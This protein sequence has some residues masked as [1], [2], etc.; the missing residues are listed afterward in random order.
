[1]LS[2]LENLIW[3]MMSVSTQSFRISVKNSYM[4]FWGVIRVN[5][6]DDM[7]YI[8][9][10]AI[11]AVIIFSAV[12]GHRRGL[13][14]TVFKCLSLAAAIILAYFFGH[15]VG[16]YIKTTPVYETVSVSVSDAVS[17]HF[18]KTALEGLDSAKKAQQDFEK[19][20]VGKTLSR[21]GFDSNDLYEKYETEILDG[22]N[23]LKENYAKKL[24]DWIISCL[25]SALGTLIVFIASLL[26]L[27]ILAKVFEAVF[28]LP[29]LKTVNKFG[30]G[31]LGL[32]LGFVYAFVACAVIEMLLPYIPEN[33]VLYMGMEEN[34]V[35]Y[36][37]FLNVN[38]LLL[39]FFG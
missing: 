6:G 10:L 15:A 24:A 16:D 3:G 34:T 23:S 28:K 12:M 18:D 29:L 35:L 38:P 4:L 11:V 30:G 13:V 21:L 36:K 20:D 32:I 14:K 33:P 9:D 2:Y 8:A 26:L 25:A 17:E 31:I 27:K 5:R 37:F 22:K 39:L 7:A 1:M 19:S